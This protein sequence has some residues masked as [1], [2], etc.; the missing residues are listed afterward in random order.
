MNMCHV[1]CNEVRIAFIILSLFYSQYWSEFFQ[2]IGFQ[3]NYR[4]LE[5]TES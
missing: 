3:T 4:Q 5:W 1:I 2:I